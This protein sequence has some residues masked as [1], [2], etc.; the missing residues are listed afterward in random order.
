[1][2]NHVDAIGVAF[3]DDCNFGIALDQM[4]DINQLAVNPGRDRGLG[5]AGADR[6][7]HLRGR[8]R[9]VVVSA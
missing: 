3:G 8:H 5:E 2:S 9:L 1:M 4:G 7:R 6:R